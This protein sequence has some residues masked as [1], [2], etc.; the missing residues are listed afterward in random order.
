MEDK[1]GLTKEHGEWGKEEEFDH[2]NDK[3]VPSREYVGT[4]ES[5]VLNRWTRH[6]EGTIWS[7]VRWSL[8]AGRQGLEADQSPEWG[9]GMINNQ[10][11]IIYNYII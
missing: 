5:L 6:M 2:R 9:K 4:R 1:E 10:E 7:N 8:L 3:H 11:L